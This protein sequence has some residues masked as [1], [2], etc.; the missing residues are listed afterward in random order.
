[1]IYLFLANGFEET[2]AI[3][4]LDILRRLGAE[5]VTVGVDG[6]YITG[7]HNIT[8]KADIL[9]EEAKDDFE[10]LILPGGMPGTDNLQ[11]SPK[12]AELIKK[13]DKEGKY[14]AA[15]CAAP[16]IL[17][18]MGLLQGKSAVCFPGYEECLEGAQISGKPVIVDDNL[19]T[20]KG[21]GASFDFGFA[22]GAVLFGQQKADELK[23]KMH[24]E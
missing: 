9:I 10:M 14:L 16:K 21:A 18:K 7:S 23:R 3:V 6:E 15:I 4:P 2:E 20:A 5:V 24:Y 13:A 19:I 8:V 12:L 1:M 22:L 17:G 11:K